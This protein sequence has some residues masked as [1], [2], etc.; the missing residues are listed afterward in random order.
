MIQA[1]A[2]RRSYVRL[3][4]VKDEALESGRVAATGKGLAFGTSF[5]PELYVRMDRDRTRTTVQE[6]VDR[7]VGQASAG[8]VD[9][10]VDD[11]MDELEIHVRGSSGRHFL[12]RLP[13]HAAPLRFDSRMEGSLRG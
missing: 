7:V 12:I 8:R 10:Q 3:G 1:R 6:A 11:H 13:K 9:V 2:F 4:D 5:N